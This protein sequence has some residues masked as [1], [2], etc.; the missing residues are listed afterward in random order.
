MHNLLLIFLSFILVYNVF[1]SYWDGHYVCT[2]HREMIKEIFLFVWS[3]KKAFLF[4]CAAILAQSRSRQQNRRIL[5]VASLKRTAAGQSR[6]ICCTVCKGKQ[7]CWRYQVRFLQKPQWCAEVSTAFSSYS[8]YLQFTCNHFNNC[9]T[10]LFSV[11]TTHR[12]IEL[13][14]PKHILIWKFQSQGG[15]PSRAKHTYP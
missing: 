11:R 4:F 10:S 6:A 14:A 5:C 2:H 8:C 15:K 3:G 13:N 7:N 9:L 1:P 12:F